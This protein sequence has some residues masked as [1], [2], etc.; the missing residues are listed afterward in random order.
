MKAVVKSGVLLSHL[1][2][3]AIALKLHDGAPIAEVEEGALRG[4]ILKSRSGREF[5]GFKGFKY[6]EA[7]RFEVNTSM[8]FNLCRSLARIDDRNVSN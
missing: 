8:A 1:V 6:G 4:K 2:L 3:Y 5:Y 7:S